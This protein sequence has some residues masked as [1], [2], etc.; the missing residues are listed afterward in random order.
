MIRLINGEAI[1]EMRKLIAEGVKVDAI[2]CDPPY[3]TIK[4]GSY[5]TDCGEWDNVIPFAPMWECLQELRKH[6][7][8]PIVLFG[9]DPFSY[10]L[11][12]S[13]EKEYRYSIIWDKV[14]A[15]QTLFAK[16]QP[17]RRFEDIMIFYNSSDYEPKVFEYHSAIRDHFEDRGYTKKDIASY[18]GY[19][20]VRNIFLDK[21]NTTKLKALNKIIEEK[22]YMLMELL[23]DFEWLTWDK[24][25]ELTLT[26]Q[27][28]YNG[29]DDK[30]KYKQNIVAI[31]KNTSNHLHPTQKPIQLMEYLIETYTN[32][33]G[34]VL[35][36]TMG[37][38]STGVAAKN[39]G[40]SFIGIEMNEQYYNAACRRINGT[41]TNQKSGSM[42]QTSLF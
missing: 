12:S 5:V 1:T 4:G 36:F 38:G 26:T 35:D 16:T 28:T 34:L 7:K 40:R 30:G 33:G 15:G 25:K 21:N 14:L 32:D 13:N 10:R 2:I 31:K 39:L 3:G 42:K 6:Q 9:N 29:K 41:E 8:T 23:P 22:Y 37:S 11:K 27:S 19:V 24:Y 17:V 18:L 20:Q